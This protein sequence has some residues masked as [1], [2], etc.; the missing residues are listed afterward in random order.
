MDINKFIEHTILKPY[1]TVADIN[2]LCEEALKY[3]FYG[4][5]LPPY[6]VREA[7][8]LLNEQAKV[9]T[10]VGFPMGYSTIPAKVEEIK[11]ALDEGADEVDLVVNICAVK[12]GHWTYI[13]NE[14]DSVARAV[15]LK[16]RVMKLILETGLLTRDE[17]RQILPLVEENDIP[18]VKTS[19]GF[20]SG[21][22][23]VDDIRYLKNQLS[24][25][26]KIKASGG[27]KTA[28]QAERLINAGASRIGTSN[29][30]ALM[31]N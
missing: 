5:C 19:T 21:G 10:V 18:F 25:R 27:I 28:E 4:V 1:T 23:T 29:G 7:V 12:S 11:K 30:V 2:R 13:R 22:A 14:L 16:G 3:G 24:A 8:R 15:A 17:T 20:N 9:I 26:T 6:F 31:K